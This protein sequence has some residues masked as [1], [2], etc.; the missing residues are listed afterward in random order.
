MISRLAAATAVA[1]TMVW[2]SVPA[3]ADSGTGSQPNVTALNRYL[4]DLLVRERPS[5]R[6]PQ[7]QAPSAPAPGARFAAAT[8]PTHI[9]VAPFLLSLAS[10]YN[11][12]ERLLDYQSHGFDADFWGALSGGRVRLRY[13]VRF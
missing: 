8:R 7:P 2:S 13:V 11:K 12:A 1:A 3:L 10:R 9:S 4:A 5:A 6:K